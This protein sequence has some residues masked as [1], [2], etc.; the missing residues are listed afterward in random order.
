MNLLSSLNR[1]SLLEELSS[2]E[3]D[4]LIIGGGITG[5]GIALDA[6][7]RG[8]KTALI[9]KQDFAAGTSSRSTK[10]IHGGLRYLKQFEINLVREVGRER[11]IV[12][13]NAPHLV[14]PEKMLLPIIKNGNYT[15]LAASI[16]LFVYDFLIRVKKE[17]RRK[18]LSKE[19]TLEIEPLLR[20]DI[21]KGAGLYV[22]YRTDD[23]RLAIE[24]IKTAAK[25]GTHAGNYLEAKKFIYDNKKIIGI[26]CEDLISHRILIIRAKQIVNA[27]GPWVD[28][29][30]KQD[31]FIK[32]KYLH[33]TKGVH[34][35][36]PSEKLPVKQSVYFDAQDGRMLFA[37][38]RG[39][40]TYFGTTDTDF[41]GKL[42]DP[43]ITKTDVNYLID[44]VNFMFKDCKLTI[45]DIISSWAGL[46]PLIHEKD[47]SPSELSRKD[48]IFISPAGLIS[49]AGG[50]LTGYRKMAQRI[51]DIV[52]ENLNQLSGFTK[53]KCKTEQIVISGG[54]FQKPSQVNDYIQ[55]VFQKIKNKGLG[56]N[57]A[58]SL[59]RTYGKQ[60]DLILNKFFE[61]N[62]SDQE[63]ALARAELWFTVNNEAVLH[64]HDFFVRRT[65]K[66]YFEVSTISKLLP[67]LLLDLKNY[68][69]LTNEQAK[70]ES[71]AMHAIVNEV[72]NFK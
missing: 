47:K 58:V 29:I 15:K 35:V 70:A 8:I 57:K 37:I 60:T 42:E 34:L 31:L 46:R 9:D 27:T 14:V 25:Y 24:I 49:I 16:G 48:E 1:S 23:A 28:E 66:L 18:I 71:D 65:G 69:N 13:S 55:E 64:L 30:R 5:A 53:V 11:A 20:K 3:Y 61:F 56:K 43:V 17:D 26:E 21:L 50:K 19:Q 4:L 36:V 63:I 10:L 39:N 41:I 54:E 33:L 6:A 51:V 7:S 2:N 38:P 40:I 22:E 52:V 72:T 45:E 59:V 32:G 67:M 12:Y 62:D 68:L 44:S